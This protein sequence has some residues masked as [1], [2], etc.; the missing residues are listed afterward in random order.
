GVRSGDVVLLHHFRCGQQRTVDVLELDAR[1]I[2]QP[3]RRGPTRVLERA[4][5]ATADRA[6]DAGHGDE[7]EEVPSSLVDGVILLRLRG[8]SAHATRTD[9]HPVHPSY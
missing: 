4:A 5:D 2:G 6:D 8:A 3:D 9:R 1:I 7:L